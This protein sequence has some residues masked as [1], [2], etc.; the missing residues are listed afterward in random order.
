MR[1]WLLAVALVTGVGG[2]ATAPAP[3]AA[4]ADATVLLGRYFDGVATVVEDGVIVLSGGRIHCAGAAGECSTDGAETVITAH[5]GL[6]LP[7]LIDLHVHAR[8]HYLAAFPAAGVTTIRDAN[9]TL[10]TL[11]ELRAHPDGPRVLASGPL[12][13][14]PG[15]IIAT[16][17]DTAAAPD[18]AQWD[19]VMPVLVQDAA[20][21]RAAVGALAERGVDVI[22][23]YE[24]LPPAAFTAAVA[25][26]RTRG[27]PVMADLGVIATR[28]LSEATVDIMEAA[29]SHRRGSMM[30]IEHLSGA[31]LAYR[32]LGGDVHAPALDAVLLDRIADSLAD[33]G[34]AVVPTLTNT[35]H[36]AAGTAPALDDVPGAGAAR[37]TLGAHWQM[38]AAHDALRDRARQDER[39]L[40]A[41]L[42]RLARRGVI[43][44]V[45][46]DTPA[47]PY[48]VP[49]GGVHQELEYLV[50]YGLTPLQA[51]RAATGDAARILQREDIGVIR[52][53]AVAD[54]VVVG[55]DP[56]SDITRTRELRWVVVGGAARQ[57]SATN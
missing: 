20:Q 2:C 25:E 27:L 42:P 31:A 7:G 47:A 52:A 38:L 18:G 40:R 23:L 12:L 14:G 17:S 54:L 34:V 1:P 53:G 8:T 19:D 11:A 28:G 41:L 29:R 26:A 37:E 22:K 15:S 3:E 21:A 56:L 57:A 4:P 44:G 10:A 46:T 16:M 49:G 39:F 33:S 48:T 32:R 51:L 43:I 5:D 30:S 45:G 9:N 50:R 55:G 6:I 24:Q 36:F 13:D 35:V